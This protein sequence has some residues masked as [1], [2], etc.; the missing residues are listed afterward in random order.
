MTKKESKDKRI[1]DILNAAVDEFLDKGYENASMESIAR[2]AGVSKGGL[3]HHFRSKDEVLLYANEKLNEPV[4][5]MKSLIKEHPCVEEGLKF[6]IR[7]YLEYWTVHKKE[8][9]FFFL[10]MTKALSYSGIFNLY[11]KYLEE[12]I[13]FFSGLF[14][15]GIESG[16]FIQHDTR[17]SAVALISALDGVLAYLVL[18]KK[19]KLD[20]TIKGFGEKFVDSVLVKK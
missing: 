10:S 17:A 14:R 18:D 19:L 3:Y 9:I 2:K 6:F 4:D 12:H 11:E 16:E 13:D 8:L 5:A 1:G 20:E 7:S 15:K